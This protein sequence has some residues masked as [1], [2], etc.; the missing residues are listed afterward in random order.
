[1]YPRKVRKEPCG[2]CL[3]AGST[4]NDVQ[5]EAGAAGAGV[6]VVAEAKM[7]NLGNDLNAEVRTEQDILDVE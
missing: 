4:V 6:Q 7:M 2:C 1:M 5:Q 3:V